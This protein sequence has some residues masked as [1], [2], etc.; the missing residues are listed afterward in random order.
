MPT[1]LR[2]IH[3]DLPSVCGRDADRHP[4]YVILPALTPEQADGLVST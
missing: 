3:D 1:E 4:W 2:C